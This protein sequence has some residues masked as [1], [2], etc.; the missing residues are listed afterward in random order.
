[1]IVTE[2][3]DG[4]LVDTPT[5]P[6]FE[7]VEL[8]TGPEHAALSQAIADCGFYVHDVD[9]IRRRLERGE[10]CFAALDGDHLASYLWTTTGELRDDALKRT[11]DL[12]DGSYWLGAWTVEE[13]RGRS[14]LSL[15]M[16]VAVEE[17]VG[18]D[19]AGCISGL[20]RTT[21]TPMRRA[22]AKTG[23]AETGRLQAIELGAG[24]RIQWISGN[25]AMM[26]RARRIHLDLAPMWLD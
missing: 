14:L 15:M 23:W 11:F 6:G 10:R 20:V 19:G 3:S 13:Y 26:R 5:P 2:V 18:P 25:A 21:N 8:T 16:L 22:L 9:D 17:C 1:M 4:R 12:G 7:V 24:I